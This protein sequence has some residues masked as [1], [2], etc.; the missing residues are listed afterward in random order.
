M[1]ENTCLNLFHLLKNDCDTE[2]KL[3]QK[4][5][6]IYDKNAAARYNEINTLNNEIKYIE[7]YYLK[8]R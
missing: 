4:E 3:H 6:E 5:K 2:N 1:M 7:L 8:Y